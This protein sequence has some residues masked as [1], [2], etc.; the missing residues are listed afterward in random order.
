MKLS[1]ILMIV[2]TLQVSAFTFGQKVTLSRKNV[3]LTAVLKDIQKLSGYNIFYDKSVVPANAL[4]DLHVNDVYVE[5]VLDGLLEKFHIGYKLVDKNI[6]LMRKENASI[7][8]T[9]NRRLTQEKIVKGNV[10]NRAGEPLAGVTVSERGKT[11]STMTDERGNYILRTEDDAAMLHFSFVG[12]EDQEISLGNRTVVDVVLV[13]R[14]DE[15]DEIVV[16][17]YGTVRKVDLTGSVAQV[18]AREVNAFPNASALQALSGRAPGVHIRQSSG[19]PGPGISVRV[20]GGNSIQGSNEPLYVIDGFPIAGSNPSIV[21][22]ADIESIEILKDASA[23]AIYGSRGANGVVIITTKKGKEGRTDVSF[24]TSYSSQR[25][26]RKLD[27]MNAQEYARFYNEQATNDNVAPYFNEEEISGFG[28]GFDW[29][30]FVFRNAPMTTAALGIAGGNEKTRFSI[31][32]SFF[33]QDGI[34]QGSNYNRYSLQSSIDHKINDKI[35]V[36]LN[37]ILSRLTTE[38]RDSGGGNRGNSMIAAA[39]SAPPILTPYNE[40][41][42]YRILHTAYPFLATDLRNPINW[43]NESTAQTKANVAL[44]NTAVSYRITPDLIF[45]VA[46]GLENRDDRSDNYTTTKFFDSPGIA[47]VSSTQQTSLL[48]ENTLNYNKTFNDNHSLAA[49]AGLTYQNFMTTAVNAG[50]TDFLSDIYETY[51]LGAA[52]T[53]G[54]P[55]SAYT[56]SVL[57]SFLGRVNYSY[58]DRYLATISFR[59]DGS[60]RYSPGSKW[61]NF[62]SAA[63]AWRISNENFM[64]NVSAFSDLKLRASWGLTGSQAIDPYTTLNLLSPG[65]TIFGNEY[66]NTVSPLTRLPNDLTWETTEQF[67]LGADVGV[68]NNRVL[69]TAD[70]YVKNTRDLLSDVRLP[71]SMGYTTTIRN[72]GKVQNRGVELGVEARPFEGSFTWNINANIAFNKNKVISLYNGEDVLR[73]NIGMVIVSDATS[74]LR[75]GRPVGQFWGYIEDGYDEKGDI[76]YRDV[77]QD[78]S[79]TSADKTYI[80]DANPDF[81][82]GFNSVMNYKNFE[83]SFFLQGTYGNDIFNASS[84]T[85]TMDYGFGLNM[86]KTVYENHWTI[87][88]TDADYPRISRSTPVKVSDRFIEDGS[89]LRLK[90]ISLAYNLPLQAWNTNKLQRLQVYVSAQNLL[91]FTNYSWWDPEVNFRLDHNSYPSAK[92]VTFGIR[93]GF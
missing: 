64:R 47:N 14:T 44:I 23:T 53:P 70:Y 49:V 1:L 80:G 84:V 89:F 43:I 38:R 33:G 91:T 21:N 37:T 65:K 60:S 5:K 39:I 83:F 48:N 66:F 25:L 90:N 19:A 62:P 31:N 77:N 87:N 29:Q 26:I 24:E 45:K 76:I 15:L 67:D 79:I 32:G 27:L 56:K 74:I 11:N 72:V 4:V 20:R 92:S 17:G 68:L 16:V 13:D 78:G 59:R 40:D 42:S 36:E 88:N 7:A 82:Y 57:I 54:V 52:G 86:P 10:T 12:Y 50:G 71:A 18:R 8:S 75:E 73:D 9:D 93:A 61:G 28:E 34:I 63:L 58:D 81:T 46:G 85:N 69:L 2:S 35:S 41:G 30:D 55:G 51:N 3:K 6:I 22:T